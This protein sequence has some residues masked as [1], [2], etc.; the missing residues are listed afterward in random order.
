V[1]EIINEP[2]KTIEEPATPAVEPKKEE[3]DVVQVLIYFGLANVI[4]IFI[5]LNV[6]FAMRYMKAKKTS[7]KT[8]DEK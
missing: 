8:T 5:G 1:P 2:V 4:L 3:T 7:E 6:F